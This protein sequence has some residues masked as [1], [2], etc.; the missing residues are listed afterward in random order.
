MVTYLNGTYYNSLSSDAKSKVVKG[1]FNVSSPGRYTDTETLETDAEQEKQYQWKG[2]VALYTVTELLRASTDSSCTS[3]NAGYNSNKSSSCKNNNWLWP[4]T[5]GEWTLSPSVDSS[6]ITVWTVQTSGYIGAPSANNAYYARPVLHLSSGITL[7]GSGTSSDPYTIVES[8]KIKALDVP[9]YSENNTTVTITYPSGCGSDLTCTY[10]KDSGE[11]VTVTSSSAS[12]NFTKDGTL[13]AKVS[14]GVN[15]VS[16]SYTYQVKS[17][18][19]T[20]ETINASQNSGY[21]SC[22]SGGSLS[23]TKCTTSSSYSASYSSGYYYCPSGYT[24][25]GSGSSMTCTKTTTTDA[26]ATYY[27]SCV[28]RDTGEV[29]MYHFLSY[30]TYSECINAG[31]DRCVDDA[32][33]HT[34]SCDASYSCSSGTLSGSSCITTSSTSASYSSGYYYCSS[35][36]TRSGT[37]CTK[38]SSYSATYNEG[39]YYCPSG[40]TSSGSGSSMK[41]TKYT[42]PSGYTLKSDNKCY[43]N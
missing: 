34:Y 22:P 12:V 18:D 1:T 10:S 11:E 4:S 28:F 35:G 40:Y 19:A 26:S 6:S 25:S 39:S 2:Y 43:L 42:C 5:S 13:V 32:L 16:S 14:D 30:N 9:T 24:S 3:L 17:I 29:S 38:T 20:K 27:L 37:T 36:G 31:E 33:I 15:T 21:Y 7:S 41:C 23:G 8:P